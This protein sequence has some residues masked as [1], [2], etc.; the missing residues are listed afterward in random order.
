MGINMLDTLEFI[1]SKSL[2]MFTDG[3]DN[4]T[5]NPQGVKDRIIASEI[6]RFAIGLDGADFNKDAL[7]ALLG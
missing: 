2:I 6:L 5:D 4:N 7:M 1:G 3:G